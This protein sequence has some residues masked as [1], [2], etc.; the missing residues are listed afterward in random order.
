MEIIQGKEERGNTGILRLSGEVDMHSSPKLRQA[1]LDFTK[2][3]KTTIGI[4]LGE[5]DYIDS[6]GLATLIEA[7]KSCK[8]YKGRM[9]LARIKPNVL[10]VFKLA[11]L[12]GFFEI[13]DA[14]P[15]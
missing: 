9:V 15:E 8:T 1:L 13:A 2:R 4:D 10:E 12:T 5:V 3:K 11:K 6:S 14:L 7:M